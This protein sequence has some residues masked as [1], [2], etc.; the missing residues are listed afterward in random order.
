MKTFAGFEGSAEKI[1]MQSFYVGILKWINLLS[2]ISQ[3]CQ[4]YVAYYFRQFI[5]S[6]AVFIHILV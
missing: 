2:A 6:L 1:S 4:E 3:V 5:I